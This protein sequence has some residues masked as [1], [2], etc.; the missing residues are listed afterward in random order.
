MPRAEVNRAA[1]MEVFARVVEESGFSAAA[2]ALGLTPSAVSKLV[3]RLEGRL[4]A[5]LVQRSTRQFA[6]TPEGQAFHE[7][8]VRILAEMEEAERAAAAGEVP[9][10]LIR[11]NTSATVNNHLLAPVLPEFLA[12]HPAIRL[13]LVLTDRVIDLVEARVDV[14]IRAGPMPESRLR[15]RKL[16]ETRLVIVG[17]PAYLAARGLP[18]RPADLAGHE[19]LGFGYARV[20]QDWPLMEDGRR[21]AVKVAGRLRA[22]DGEGLRRLALAGAGLVRLAAFCV[23]EDI[24]AGRLLPVLEEAN[25]GDLEA[26]HAVHAGGAGPMPAR[27]RA[28]LDFLAARV[29]IRGDIGGG[30]PV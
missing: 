21:I 1:E 12:T 13:D 6:L 3:A 5:R 24:A 15:A 30:A 14:A 17:A 2:R 10:G 22:S 18:R 9:A 23:R 25:T 26:F 29:R 27:V 28:L 11:V 16:G 4:G 7:R 8:T 19:L 20:I